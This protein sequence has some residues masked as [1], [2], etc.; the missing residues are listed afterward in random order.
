MPIKL[1]LQVP[2]LAQALRKGLEGAITTL[3]LLFDIILFLEISQFVEMQA[4]EK[5]FWPD[6]MNAQNIQ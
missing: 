2:S 4:L 6:Q 5:L 3:N 1:K